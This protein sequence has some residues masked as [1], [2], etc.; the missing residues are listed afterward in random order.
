[1]K[2]RDVLKKTLF[3]IANKIGG[4]DADTE[5]K[6]KKLTQLFAVNE[7][8]LNGIG[9]DLYISVKDHINDIIRGLLA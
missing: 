7:K 8:T 3:D 4:A 6:V 9:P 2:D 5:T 1:V